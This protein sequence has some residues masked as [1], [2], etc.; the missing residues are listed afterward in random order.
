[1]K[2]DRMSTVILLFQ[3]LLAQ[4]RQG[5]QNTCSALEWTTALG[6]DHGEQQD[7]NEFSRLLFARMSESFQA[8]A[9]TPAQ[10]SEDGQN[11][12]ATLLS[13]LFQGT[14]LYETK[15]SKCLKTSSRREDFEDINLPIEQPP[16]VK[17]SLLST[18]WQPK[19]KADTDVQY[20]FERYSQEELMEGDNKYFCSVC[21]EK[22]DA[23]RRTVFEKLPPCLNIQLCR[24][25]YDRTKGEKKK[26][27]TKVLLPTE[28]RV[29]SVDNDSIQQNKYVLCAVM[30]HKGVSAYSGHYVAEAMDWTSG[31]WF[32]FNDETLTYLEHGPTCSIDPNGKD[33]AS[34]DDLE[35][36]DKK[37]K[38]VGSN[39]AYCLYYVEK[40]F[41]A[42]SVYDR[43]R[44]SGGSSDA[45]K[46]SPSAVDRVRMDREETYTKLSE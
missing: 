5:S 43:L 41:L 17:R 28:L 44:E 24:Y 15:C 18:F 33:E 19:K 7:P 32:E 27:A 10:R 35:T 29:E 16:P 42:Q 14:I 9:S 21:N 2:Q 22:Q 1:M 26:L 23:T 38:L 20:C 45:R 46:D 11:N 30:R 8:L 39:E 37:A 12:L 3:E 13:D 36:T 34:D 6:L 31:Q 40:K 4:M 25:V